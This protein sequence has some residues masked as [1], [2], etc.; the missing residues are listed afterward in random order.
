MTGNSL[1]I[2][3]IMF[4]VSFSTAPFVA[5]ANVNQVFE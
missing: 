5:I 2:Y 4:T 1:S 3:T